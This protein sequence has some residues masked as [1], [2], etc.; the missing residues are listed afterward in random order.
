MSKQTSYKKYNILGVDVDA[1]TTKEAIEYIINRAKT[2]RPPAYVVKP[3]VEFVDHAVRQPELAKL[4]N[5][6]EVCLPDGI[7]L[8][9]A[10]YYLYGGKPGIIRLITSLAMIVTNPKKIRSLL[11]DRIAG[12]NFTWPLLQSAAKHNL[13]VFLIGS[14]KKQSIEHTSNLLRYRIAGLNVVGHFPGHFDEVQE[15]EMTATLQK[16]QPDIVLV[17]I[18]FPRQ[19]LLMRRLARKLHHGVLIGEGGSFDYQQFGGSL[20]KAPL[21]MQDHGLEW[22][23]RLMKQPWRVLRMLAIPRFVWRVFI[24]SI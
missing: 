3:Y 24:S 6:A 18:G 23:W 4:L 22:L 5:E 15:A 7:A 19:E 16:T 13:K 1:V 9:W 21:W 11:P 17:A 12:I 2:N 20:A 8:N 14:P 10:A